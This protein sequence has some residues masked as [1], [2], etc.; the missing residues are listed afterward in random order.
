MFGGNGGN[1][2]YFNY[3]HRSCDDTGGPGVSTT[4]AGILSVYNSGYKFCAG[5]PGGGSN[6]VNYGAGAGGNGEFGVA[7]KKWWPWRNH[8]RNSRIKHNI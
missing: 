8:Y 2:Y 1:G 4:L 5:G 3:S 6:G 7:G